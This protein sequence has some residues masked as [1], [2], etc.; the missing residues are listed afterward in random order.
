M[1]VGDVCG[2]YRRVILDRHILGAGREIEC[3]IAHDEYLPDHRILRRIHHFFLFCQRYY[4]AHGAK[5]LAYDGTL[6]LV[7]HSF[8]RCIGDCRANV[9]KIMV[10]LAGLYNYAYSPYNEKVAISILN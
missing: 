5:T 1:A 3:D 8:G 9:G 2:K 10:I 6:F 7:E 4:N